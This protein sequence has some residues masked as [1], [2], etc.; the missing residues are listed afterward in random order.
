MFK[1]K[2]LVILI[3]VLIGIQFIPYGKDHTNPPSKVIAWDSP[4]TQE[5]FN[6]SCADCHSN[7][8]KWRW[9][10]TIAP[11]SWLAYY[12]VKDGRKHF[13]VSETV[14]SRKLDEAI[15]EI[16]EN[17]MPVLQY[18]LIHPDAKLSIQ[19]RDELI[20]GLKKTFSNN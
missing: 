6:K 13:N 18:T 14:T 9:Y 19:E 12:D 4:R 10:T 20:R 3:V 11:M 2:N 7:N 17:E 1:I 8:T 16:E 15:E 5:L